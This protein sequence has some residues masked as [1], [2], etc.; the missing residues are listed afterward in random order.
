MNIEIGARVLTRDRTEVGRVHRIV[1]DLEQQAV[2]SIVVLRGR[3][4][5]RDILVPIDFVADAEGDELRLTLSKDKLGDLP[6]FA[7]NEFFTPPPTWAFT[8]PYP[9][10][11][12]YIPVRQRQRMSANQEDLLPGTRVHAKDGPLGTVDQV[13]LEPDTDHLDG[14]WVRCETAGVQDVYVPVDWV[15]RLDESGVY[16]DATITEVLDRLRD[17]SLARRGER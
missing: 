7:Y 16:L 8:L 10:G 13:E 2:V 3:L 9:G 14:F 17:I 6:D 15:T 4:L 11:V 1:V 12:L 5:P